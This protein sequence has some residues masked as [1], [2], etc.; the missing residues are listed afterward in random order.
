MIIYYNTRSVFQQSVFCDI[1]RH[2][3]R[4][5]FL[6][7]FPSHATFNN[8]YRNSARFN[9]VHYAHLHVTF[10]LSIMAVSGIHLKSILLR[11]TRVYT[12][13]TIL[14]HVCVCEKT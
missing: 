14:P 11:Y 2:F 5:M 4:T 7:K 8:N 3:L 13:H 9:V 12:I 10:N 1:L 6:I